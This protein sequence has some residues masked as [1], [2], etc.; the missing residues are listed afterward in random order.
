MCFISMYQLIY[1]RIQPQQKRMVEDLE[2]RI[3]PLFD[4][5]N[6]ETLSPPVCDQLV[7]LTQGVYSRLTHVT[8]R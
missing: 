8:P 4:A 7:Q 2:R 1:L 6:C 5:L 3:G